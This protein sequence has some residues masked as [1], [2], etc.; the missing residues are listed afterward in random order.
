MKV[1]Q[2]VKSGEGAAL[3]CRGM[4]VATLLMRA[5]PAEMHFAAGSAI[6]FLATA[7]S[8]FASEGQGAVVHRMFVDRFAIEAF[9]RSL[10]PS[11]QGLTSKRFCIVRPFEHKDFITARRAF[12]GGKEEPDSLPSEIV[13]VWG[14][15][16][17]PEAGTR[18]LGFLE[19]GWERWQTDGWTWQAGGSP[20]G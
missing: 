16:V 2:A 3:P 15:G 5:V 18:R 11:R 14:I 1:R 10:T 7:R 4:F 8:G 17:P 19:K 20:C 9:L 13:Q 12:Y 6:R